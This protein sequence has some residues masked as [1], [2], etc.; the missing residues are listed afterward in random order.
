MTLFSSRIVPDQVGLLLD[1]ETVV[2]GVSR[3][4]IGP[5]V[6]GNGVEGGDF[7]VSFATDA[8]TQALPVPLVPIDPLGSLIYQTP[9]NATGTIAFGGDTDDFTITLDANQ[10]VTILVGASSG[11][12]PTVSLFDSANNQVGTTAIAPA[13]GARPS[14]RPR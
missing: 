2:D 8:A 4:P 12:Q 5:G 7:I 1:G 9:Y 6:S 11:L 10:T 3:W 13:P 14:T